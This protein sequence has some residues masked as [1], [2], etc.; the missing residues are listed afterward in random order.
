MPGGG[1]F[2][3]LGNPGGGRSNTLHAFKALNATK[4]WHACPSPSG[5]AGQA[6]AAGNFLKR[7]LNRAEA[8]AL[9]REGVLLVDDVDLL[10]P[11]ALRDLERLNALGCSVVVSAA[12]SPVLL[13][14][15]PL[16]MNARLAGAGLLLAPRSTADGDLFGIRLE[17]EPDPPPGR[18]VLISDGRSCPVQVAWAG[19]D[20]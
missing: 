19:A 7:L 14:H 8:G 16:L 3:V 13:Q 20:N 15:V 11:P 10:A 2:A 18:G 9:S 17:T 6:E 4:L 5:A 1:L 12:Y